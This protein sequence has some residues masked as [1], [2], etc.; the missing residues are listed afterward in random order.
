MS[1]SFIDANVGRAFL[2]VLLILV[3]ST[4]VLYILG[5]T[6]PTS[7]FTSLRLRVRSWWIMAGVFAVAIVLGRTVSLV[8]FGLISFLALKEYLSLIPTRRVDRS[9]LLWVY[10]AIPVQYLWVGME[11][12]SMF[13]IFIPVYMFLFLPIRMMMVGE[14]TGFLRSVGTIHWGLMTTVFSLSHA[15]FLFALPAAGNPNGGGA[16]LLLYL[17][18][19]TQLNDVSQFIWGKLFG[20]HKVVPKASPGKTWEGLIGGVATTVLLAVLIAP[21]L[22]PL[23]T[24]SSL[25][26]GGL[27]GI[28]GFFGDVTISC[29]KRDL[30]IKDSSSLIPGHGGILDRVDSL[31]YTAPLF[32]HFVRYFYFR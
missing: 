2:G 5:K 3:A 24:W 7:D 14:T 22:T 8:F 32:F 26:A 10:L 17:V 13:I 25:F 11:S 20:R 18:F 23:D 16:G 19:L 21:L 9:V 4:V 12:Y 27:I 28:A 30:G 31:T 15:A 6:K 1:T 29:L